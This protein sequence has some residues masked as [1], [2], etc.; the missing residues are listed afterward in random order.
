M[1]ARVGNLAG[2]PADA[3]R[4][5][6]TD[7]AMSLVLVVAALALASCSTGHDDGSH[8][9]GTAGRALGGSPTAGAVRS[10]ADAEPA[11]TGTA[12]A[13]AHGSAHRTTTA[14]GHL[15]PSPSRGGSTATT[16]TAPR[17]GGRAG[18][19]SSGTGSATTQQSRTAV[20]ATRV[21]TFEP[22]TASG[23]L[24]S[25][26]HASGSATGTCI[27]AGVAGGAS[28][29]CF[30]SSPGGI[31]DPCFAGPR[32]TSEPLAC[33]TSP[34]DTNVVMLRATS[35][36]DL[37]PVSLPPRPWAI[38][39]AGGTVCTLVNAAWDGLGPFGCPPVPA[40]G[41]DSSTSA[42]IHGSG[43]TGPGAAGAGATGTSTTRAG[44]SLIGTA[45]GTLGTAA[46]AS[47]ATIADCHQPAPGS[48][49]WTAACQAV[50]STSSPF[51]AERV[52]VVWR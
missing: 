10:S 50:Q 3:R 41:P 12:L 25:P 7:R 38:E 20:D 4:G 52:V 36:Q 2:V 22:F 17:T 14:P 18:R 29:R 37:V 31:F 15:V 11:R 26:L 19:A 45:T 48:P 24:A 42:A 32:G 13:H 28:Y 30:A 34:K 49:W 51:T 33:V 21:V 35:I 5:A 1:G 47:G 8:P 27:D 6:G 43:A 39:L 23:S 46:T 40:A 9:A 44:Q 16:R